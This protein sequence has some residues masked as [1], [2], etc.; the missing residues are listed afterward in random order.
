MYKKEYLWMSIQKISYIIIIQT[1][2]KFVQKIIHWQFTFS[3]LS[4][5]L[6]FPSDESSGQYSITS[7]L[8]KVTSF[9]TLGSPVDEWTGLLLVSEEFFVITSS[10][11]KRLLSSMKRYF[12]ELV[13]FL[14]STSFKLGKVFRLLWLRLT[15]IVSVLSLL[16]DMWELI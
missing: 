7:I 6:L 14:F 3:F 15:W 9:F 10:L 5:P 4:L 8:P 13:T 11:L 16:I 1:I 12:D 2:K